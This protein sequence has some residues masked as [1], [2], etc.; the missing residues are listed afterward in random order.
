MELLLKLL[1]N[2]R[3]RS[4]INDEVFDSSAKEG[5]GCSRWGG[6]NRRTAVHPSVSSDTAPRMMQP[7]L[8]QEGLGTIMDWTQIPHPAATSS[9]ST[10][11]WWMLITSFHT[12]ILPP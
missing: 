3:L 10:V 1:N 4:P 11:F 8:V 12:P 5:R 9:T 6:L 2:D 7:Y